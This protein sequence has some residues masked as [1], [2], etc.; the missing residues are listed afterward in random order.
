MFTGIIT[1]LGEVTAVA[2]LPS[3]VQLVLRTAYDLTAIPLGASI[4]HDGACLTV[5][6]K[7][8]AAGCYTVEVS[9][10]TLAKTTI[11][12]WK[13]GTKVNLER[14]LAVGGEYGGHMVTG[15]VDGLGEVA[16]FEP[17]GAFWLLDIDFPDA[18]RGMIAPKGSVAVNG[19]SLTVNAVAKNVLSITLIPHTAEVTNLGGL[20][21][22]D[23]VNLEIDLI[24]RYV[25]QYLSQRQTA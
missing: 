16:R 9:T 25:A 2:P 3:G 24:A 21:R 6:A 19:V 4:A 22:G 10:E 8:E 20:Q 17:Q 18:M 12:Q 15:H 5:V 11:G 23:T 13:T 7:D 14:P 1:D